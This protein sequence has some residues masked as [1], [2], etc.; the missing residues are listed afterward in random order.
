M[1][2]EVSQ[3]TSLLVASQTQNQ[4]KGSLAVSQPTSLVASQRTAAAMSLM[5]SV[6]AS[7]LADLLASRLGVAPHGR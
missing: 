3:P 5:S 7:G 1:R 4:S 2:E 6:L